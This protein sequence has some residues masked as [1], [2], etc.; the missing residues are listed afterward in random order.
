MKCGFKIFLTILVLLITDFSYGQNNID[1]YF[2]NNQFKVFKHE[3]KGVEIK[4]DPR[5]EFFQVIN[6]VGGNPAINTTEMNY[7][8]DIIRY[9]EKYKNNEALGYLKNNFGKFFTSIDGP[10]SFLLCLNNDF[11][12][13]EDVVNNKWRDLPEIDTYL[14]MMRVFLAETDFVRFFNDQ[15][16]FYNLVLTNTDFTLNDF[17]EKNRILDY[18][19]IENA[20]EHKFCLILNFLGFGNFGKGFFTPNGEEHYAIVSASSGNGSIPVFEK[21]KILAL[22]WHEFGHSFSNPLVDKYWDDFNNLSNLLEPIKQSM[23]GQFYRDWHSVVYEHMVRAV[24]CRLGA[25]KYSEDFA[26]VNLNRIEL[27]Q[28]FIYTVPII[29]ALHKYEQSRSRYPNLD[30]FMP[31]IITALNSVNQDSINKWLS[32]ALQIREPDISDIPSNGEIYNRDNRLL[33]LATNEEDSA[34]DKRLKEFVAKSCTN[35]K[36][37]ADTTALEM[38]LSG[39]NLF[40][41]GT[42]W[43]NKFIEKYMTLLPVKITRQGLVAHNVYEGNGYAFITGWIN[44]F[45][46]DNIMVIYT[47]QNP[48]DLVNFTWI[49]RGGTDYQ[50]VKNMITL[51]EDDYKR[52][53]L[54]WGCY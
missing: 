39:Y 12:F 37:V 18:F 34:A 10:Y 27:G 33:I 16:N 20:D 28:K 42:P 40:A 11:T 29:S 45:N 38:D 49:P 7:K 31:E 6:L 43:G 51:R 52:N 13:R 46:A 21:N 53:N 26:Q 24:T 5:I 50:I 36:T 41:I 47:A 35:Y 30:S 14:K 15:E 4:I 22:M 9:F 19:G 48:D 17:D 44:P 3:I 54:I 8:L 32:M 25:I 23:A 2:K 1:N